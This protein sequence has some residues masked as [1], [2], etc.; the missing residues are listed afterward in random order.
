MVSQIRKRDGTLVLFTKQRIVD[1]VWKALSAVGEGDKKQAEKIADNVENIL[2]VKYGDKVAPTVENVQD[3]VEEVLMINGFTKAA[4][5]YILYRKQHQQLRDVAEIVNSVEIIDNYINETDWRVR[6]NANMTFSLQG[7]NN[8]IAGIVV[9]NYWLNKIYP[10]EIGRMHKNAVFHIHDLSIL[11]A[12]CVGWDLQDLLMTGFRGVPGK[13]TSAPP[14]H[15]RTAFGQIVNYIYTLQGET[16][17][18]QAFSDFDTYLAPFIRYDGLDYK[19]VKQM[20]QEF[21]FNMNVP[22][23]VGFQ[24][25]FSNITVNIKAPSYMKNTPVIIGGKLLDDTYGDFQDEMNMLNQAFAEVMMEGDSNGRVFTFPIPTYNITKDFDWEDDNPAIRGVFEMTAKYGVPYFSNFVNS[26]MNPED[27][28]S[29]CCHLRLDNR[30]LRKRGGGLFGANPLTG[31]IGVVT[32]NMPQIGYL[33]KS[34]DEY[35]ERLGEVMD[36][37][38]RALIIKRKI[39]EK[40]TEMGLYPY[41]KFYLRNIKKA[42]GEYWTNHFSTIGLIGLNESMINFMGSDLTHQEGIKF[43]L[44][45]MDFMRDRLRDYQ[46][47]TGH[48]YNLEATPAEGT[49]YR[50]ARIDKKRYPNV[51][52]ANEERVREERAAPY[53]TNSS[54]LHVGANLDIFD[55]LNIQDD[56]QVKYTG[57]TVFHTFLGEKV[58]DWRMIREMVKKI[59]YNFKL[60]YFTITP[61]FSVC[62]VHGYIPGEHKYCPVCDREIGYTNMQKVRASGGDV[63]QELLEEVEKK[64]KKCEVY[65]RVVGYIRP[66]SQWNDGKQE[67]FKERHLFG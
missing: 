62:P 23:R 31:S 44:K 38:K 51:I 65:S 45:V 53:Y 30:E 64:R 47:E 24:T 3:I 1:A 29:M 50:L 10:P 8:H 26:D 12:Y 20:M 57:G 39:L 7:L 54:L 55:A 19:Q 59:S 61:T 9:T 43:G 35:F 33:S 16:A 37:A 34:E 27:A 42:Y 14:K 48:N 5:A 21:L 67:E 11:G 25:P 13:I 36:Y 66:V 46:E 22:T 41:T 15:L 2:D 4:K 32:I 60:P 28:R 63:D 17:G 52:V 6:E 18:A 49:S 58:Y 56:F 40:Y